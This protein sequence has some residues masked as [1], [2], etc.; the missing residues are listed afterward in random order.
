MSANRVRRRMGTGA[1][2][3]SL[4]AGLLFDDRGGR[5]TPSHATKGKRRYRYYVTPSDGDAP[6]SPE[7]RACRI[8]AHEFEDVVRAE[9]LAVLTS[10]ARLDEI[11]EL[12]PTAPREKLNTYHA[13]AARAQSLERAPLATC[14]AFLLFVLK[15]ITV[16]PE[17]ID[18]HIRPEAFR[19]AIHHEQKCEDMSSRA[20]EDEARERTYDIR[21]KARLKRCGGETRLVLLGDGQAEML[22]RPDPVLIKAVAK[23]RVW[24]HQLITGEAVS[25]AEI[26]KREGTSRPHASRLLS[27]AFLAPDLVEAILE[28]KQPPEVN[29]KVLTRGHHLPLSWND[30]RRV[31]G[32]A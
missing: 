7:H 10:L 31:L 11:L 17:W 20:I 30:Q 23:A 1:K 29:V 2:E 32:F 24:A 15:R 5:L 8:P 9:M 27:L 6:T 3:A 12:E 4:L 28:G 16:G 25:I 26:A 13:A 21:I 14:R 19:L 18:L 22:P